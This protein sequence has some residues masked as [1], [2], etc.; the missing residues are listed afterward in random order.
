MSERVNSKKSADAAEVALALA[1]R[2]PA[3]A[4]DSEFQ[5]EVR[6]W[7]AAFAPLNAEAGAADKGDLWDK[8]ADRLD[9]DAAAP[10]T[11]TIAADEGVWESIAR[12]VERKVTNVN[13]DKGLQSYLV[14]MKKGAILP[15]HD[16]PEEEHCVVISGVLRLGGREFGA[17]AYHY[18]SKDERHL[19]ISAVEDAVFFIHGAL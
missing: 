19:A 7:E 9:E 12:G 13:R 16:H 8:I 6:F 1:I 17:G 14:R 2:D 5:A 4:E 15:P 11:R 10:G 18:A 3:R